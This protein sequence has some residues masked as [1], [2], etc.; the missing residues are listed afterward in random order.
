M[1]HDPRTRLVVLVVLAGVG[2]SLAGAGVALG[3]GG[4]LASGDRMGEVTVAGTNVT[5]AGSDG[6]VVLTETVPETSDIEISADGGGITVAEQ[7]HEPATTF[8]QREREQAIEIAHHNG[9]IES[10]LETVADPTFSV[11]PIEELNT[12]EMQGATVTFSVNES[13]EIDASGDH[14]RVLK[15]T[16]VTIEESDDSVTVDRE[17]A[18]VE[19]QAVVHVGHSDRQGARY[20]V[21]VD[22]ANGTVVDITDWEDV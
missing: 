13:D 4:V 21:R 10:Y 5:V 22:L 1:N 16:N 12:T 14:G 7:P 20:W 11:H 2:V 18:Y 3:G 15:L 8:T 6:D 9:T 19:D 17:P